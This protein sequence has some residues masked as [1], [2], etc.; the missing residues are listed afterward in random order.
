[1]V[2]C[3]FEINE[4]KVKKTKRGTNPLGTVPLFAKPC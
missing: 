3:L 4:L 2:E 1:M